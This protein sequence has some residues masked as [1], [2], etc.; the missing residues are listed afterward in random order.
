MTAK[1][2]ILF[3]FD[4]E[5]FSHRPGTVENNM[6]IPAE[7]ILQTCESRNIK[8]T[9]F[10]EAVFILKLKEQ[11]LKHAPLAHDYALLVRQLRKMVRLGHRIELHLHPYWLDA[12]TNGISWTIP[13]YRYNRLQSMP[14]EKAGNLFTAGIELLEKIARKENSTYKIKAFR[15][16]GWCLQPFDVLK[17]CF[18]QHGISIDSSVAPGIKMETPLYIADFS[19]ISPSTNSYFFDGNPVEPTKNGFLEISITTFKRSF[20]NKI[21]N[22]IKTRSDEK[23]FYR[24]GDGQEVPMYQQHMFHKIKA[25]LSPS[26]SML[27]LEGQIDKDILLNK[28]IALSKTKNIL[29][30][31]SHPK[32]M[33]PNSIEIMKYLSD[34]NLFQFQTLTDLAERDNYA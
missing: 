33:S 4:Y 24:F 2:T 34:K 12:M 10:V 7:Q 20:F 23:L 13:S 28:I 31:I 3:T 8:V 29:T 14:S 26:I 15:A 18:E 9:F 5:M 27:T 17:K 30:F 25:I 32:N 22:K 19:T 21:L 11:S 6:I 1:P 16:G